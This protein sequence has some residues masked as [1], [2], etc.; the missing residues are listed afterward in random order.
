MPRAQQTVSNNL[1]SSFRSRQPSPLG[2]NRQG[3]RGGLGD[4]GG[5]WPDRLFSSQKGVELG[6]LSVCGSGA[7]VFIPRALGFSEARGSSRSRACRE[8]QSSPQSPLCQ[9]S[10]NAP[11]S[12][13]M[14]VLRRQ[15]ALLYTIQRDI[16][17]MGCVS[18]WDH[19]LLRG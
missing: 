7:R 5:A 11:T 12:T 8:H 13:F 17:R 19:T 18:G 15:T 14:D 2:L 4:R 6:P 16:F 1:L 3:T 10:R 9:L